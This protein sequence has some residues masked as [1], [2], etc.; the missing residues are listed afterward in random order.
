MND[1]Q[2]EQKADIGLIGLAVMGRNLAMNMANHGY[3][4]QVYNR[5]FEVTKALMDGPGKGSGLIPSYDL[6]DFCKNIKSP[7]RIMLMVKAGAAVDHLIDQLSEFLSSGDLIVDG[8]NSFY[9]DSIRRAEH[10]KGHGLN[11][12]GLGVSGGEE[13]ALHGPSLMPG[14]SKEAYEMIAPVLEDISAVVNDEPCVTY[15]GDGGAGHFVKMVH[16]G[17]EYG[18]MQ[19]ISEAYDI[20]K[21][22][23]GLSAKDISQVFSKWNQGELQSYLIEITSE[24]LLVMDEKTGVPLVEMILDKAGQKGT[25]LWTVKAALDLGVSVPTIIAAVNGRIISGY[26]DL[27]TQASEALPGPERSVF[28]NME[29]IKDWTS[30]LGEALYFAKICSY[31]QGYDLMRQAAGKYNWSLDMG[32]IAR[33]WRGGCII[34]ARFLEDIRSAYGANPNL[35]NLLLDPGLGHVIRKGSLALRKIISQV[36]EIG[37]PVPALSASLAYYDSLKSSTLPANL[38]QGMRDYFGAHTYQRTD[39]DGTFHTDWEA[40]LSEQK[41]SE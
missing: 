26:K 16:N 15:I 8:G 29:N 12:L 31:A 9:A 34:R 40:A 4:V 33:I 14:G 7:R 24:L 27:R 28:Q 22:G 39:M 32:E 19:L 36:I 21:R 11:F 23:V 18:D 20:L 37:I 25:G 2:N 13:G 41:K 10:L 6:S 38:I 35:P 1:L 5:S 3:R 30:T 17:I